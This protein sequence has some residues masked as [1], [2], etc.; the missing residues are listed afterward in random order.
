MPRNDPKAIATTE[1]RAKGGKAK[2]DKL[3]ADRERRREKADALFASAG[4]KAVAKLVSL[5]DSDDEQIR[6]RASVAVLDRA[7][8]KPSQFVEHEGRVQLDVEIEAA[9]AKLDDLI[10]KRSA[11]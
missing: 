6:L 10:S 8:G 2:A 4:E 11:Q 3:R 1:S 7:Y 9:R 5:M